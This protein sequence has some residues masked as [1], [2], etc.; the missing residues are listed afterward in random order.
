MTMATISPSGREASSAGS[1]CESSRLVMLKFHLVA[2]A[3][4]RK[5]S[6]LIFFFFWNET[7][8]IAKEGG[9]VGREGSH[10]LAI[11]HQGGGAYQSCGALVAPLWYFFRPVFFI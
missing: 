10:K 9:L 2:A 8:H 1:S 6:R 5:S 3:K 4:P 7:L 11:R